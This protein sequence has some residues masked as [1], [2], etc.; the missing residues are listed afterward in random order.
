MNVQSWSLQEILLFSNNADMFNQEQQLFF[1]KLLLKSLPHYQSY[2][3]AV[4][5]YASLLANLLPTLFRKQ[6]WADISQALGW[7]EELSKEF[8]SSFFRIVFLYYSGLFAICQGDTI[9]GEK[10]FFGH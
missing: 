6:E 8:T 4:P 3:R 9:A 5:V 10:K 2:D 1:F 7:L